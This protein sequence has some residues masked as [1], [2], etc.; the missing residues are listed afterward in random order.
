MAREKMCCLSKTVESKISGCLIG[1][2]S[3][4]AGL[5]GCE[6]VSSV[7]AKQYKLADI[8]NVLA[9]YDSKVVRTVSTKKSNVKLLIEMGKPVSMD[10][11]QFLAYCSYLLRGANL[12]GGV[13]GRGAYNKHQTGYN[14]NLSG[15]RVSLAKLFAECDM[16]DSKLST[17]VTVK[18]VTPI[19]AENFDA[20][21]NYILSLLDKYNLTST[22]FGRDFSRQANK[23]ANSKNKP[24]I[25]FDNGQITWRICHAESAEMYLNQI[26]LCRTLTDLIELYQNGEIKELVYKNR[27]RKLLEKFADGLAIVQNRSK[28]QNNDYK[29]GGN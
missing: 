28:F 25:A 16:T 9:L 29:R 23:K 4:K 15:L 7:F 10:K 5:T 12:M 27:T 24:A 14:G 8:E 20:C 18:T 22:L 21:T 2:P 3:D 13:A 19:K 11:E 26:D 17:G 6:Y 1:V